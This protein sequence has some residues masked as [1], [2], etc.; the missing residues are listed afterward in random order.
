MKPEL[1]ELALSI[2]KLYYIGVM[3]WEEASQKLSCLLQM[4]GYSGEARDTL[5]FFF[6]GKKE[7]K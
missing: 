5:I 1:K 7:G 2:S 3:N 6:I 4:D